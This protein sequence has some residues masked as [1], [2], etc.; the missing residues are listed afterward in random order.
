MLM[1]HRPDPRLEPAEVASAVRQLMAEGRVR[2]VGVSNMSA[3]QIELLRDRLGTP[4][5]ADQLEM[6]LSA[7]SWLESTVQVN[8]AEGTD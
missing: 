6:R 1:L 5:V 4:V 8:H 2:A 3:P 7:R